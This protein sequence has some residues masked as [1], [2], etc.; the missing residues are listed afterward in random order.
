MSDGPVSLTAD[1]AFLG[2]SECNLSPNARAAA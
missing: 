1:T 2:E